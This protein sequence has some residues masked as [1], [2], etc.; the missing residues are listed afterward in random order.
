MGII[1][2]VSQV[3]FPLITYP[4]VSRILMPDGIGRVGFVSSA[5]NIFS[6][7]AMLGIPTYGIKACARVRDDKD[8]LSQVVQEILI[9]NTVS[10]LASYLLLLISVL[11]I[12]QF[13][14]ECELFALMS[15][16]ILLTVFGVEW[17]YQSIEQYDYITIR[18]IITK[19]LSV[20]MMFV[21]VKDRSDVLQYGAVTII[22][23]VGS[24]ILNILRLRKFTS[25]RKRPEYDLRRHLKPIFI[26]FIFSAVTTIYTSLDSVMLRMMSDINEVGYYSTSIKIRSVL[27]NVITVAASVLMPRSSYLVSQGMTEK[28]Y[29]LLKRS[30][31][32]VFILAVPSIIFFFVEA[33]KVI[34]IIS[35][36]LF[37]PS[38]PSFQALVFSLLFIGMTNVIGFQY[39]I[40]LGK[41]TLVL[42]ST[43]TGAVVDVILNLLFIPSY[44]AAGA[45]L[46]TSIAECAV[47]IV[48]LLFVRNIISKTFSVKLIAKVIVASLIPLLF[49]IYENQSIYIEALVDA[50]LYGCSYILILCI[51]H[52]HDV[53][54]FIFSHM[55]PV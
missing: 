2:K 24:N 50:L 18:S 44:G 37:L 45:A 33:D 55:K 4:Y 42:F 16:T 40:T 12:P 39:L 14:E 7:I 51:L 17:F 15:I 1:L 8:K 19:L 46:A 13:R 25:L 22:G 6:I 43:V 52:Y 26:L 53:K 20:V 38:V 30:M 10:M 32:F 34:T 47:F 48:Q 29:E 21:L 49:L 9:I 35:G 11:V 31:G 3:L 23:T 5:L 54:E 27:L 41:D 36:D 28:Y